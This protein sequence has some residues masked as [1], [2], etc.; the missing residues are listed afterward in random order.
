[1]GGFTFRCDAFFAWIEGVEGI[2]SEL[3]HHADDEIKD[4]QQWKE[5]QTEERQRKDPHPEGRLKVSFGEIVEKVDGGVEDQRPQEKQKKERNPKGG[6]KDELCAETE[7]GLHTPQAHDASERNEES[8][9]ECDL[10]NGLSCG[11][12][13]AVKDKDA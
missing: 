13:V 12:C 10:V 11:E 1:M 9:E 6:T 3:A 7:F 8:E 2:V 5:Q 4:E